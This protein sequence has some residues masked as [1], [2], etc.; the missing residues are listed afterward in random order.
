MMQPKVRP[1]FG[2]HAG[3]G[4]ILGS[5]LSANGR[6][7]LYKKVPTGETPRQIQRNAIC[8]RHRLQK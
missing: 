5:L 1:L 2:G 7:Y 4:L 6:K 8:Y 3:C